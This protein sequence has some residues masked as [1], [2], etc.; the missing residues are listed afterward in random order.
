[1]YRAQSD[2]SIS[3]ADGERHGGPLQVPT[4]FVPIACG[5]LEIADRDRA[6]RRPIRGRAG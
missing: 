4:T 1:M 2:P 3:A 5:A 6:E